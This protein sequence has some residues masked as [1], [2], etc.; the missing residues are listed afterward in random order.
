M[1]DKKISDLTSG[2]A[3]A[4]T[5]VMEVEQGGNSRKLTVNDI[6]K[7]AVIGTQAIWIPAGAMVANTTS[8]PATG[9][10]EATTNKEMLSTYDFDASSVESV[11]FLIRMPKQWNE[12]TITYA[13]TWKHAAT[14]TNF[15][16]AWDLAGYAAS[17]GDAADTAFGT[18]IQVNDTG[19]TT[20]TI[21]ISPTSA[22]VTIAGTPA[23]EDLVFFR[24][25]RVATD[26]TNDTLAIDAGLLGVTL[27]ITTDAGNDA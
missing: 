8:G 12:G 5:E 1:T 4:G 27:Y 26:G 22:A 11:Q 10:V 6:S 3:P 24:F 19:G 25:R 13:V 21:Y 18:A 9:S 17:D 2:T 15:K 7:Q 20:N 14:T 23:A 16:V